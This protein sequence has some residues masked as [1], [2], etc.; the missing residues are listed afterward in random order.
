MSM[1]YPSP[2][3][4]G[5]RPG[6]PDKLEIRQP[7]GTIKEI[8]HTALYEPLDA[9]AAIVHQRG[10]G[11]GWG[12]ALERD[13]VKVRDDVL[14]EYVSVAGARRD[15]GVALTG[16]A[17]DWSLEVDEAATRQLRAEMRKERT[18]GNGQAG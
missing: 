7:D 16:S 4:N 11:G 9:G 12:D 8:T 13:P 17:D 10:G 2:G 3:V 6:T 18:A 14:D 1:K 15:Y 5:G